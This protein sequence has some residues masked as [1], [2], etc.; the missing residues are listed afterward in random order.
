MG[1]VGDVIAYLN[2]NYFDSTTAGL[3]AVYGYAMN[4][5]SANENYALSDLSQMTKPDSWSDD[6]WDFSG[7]TPILKQNTSGATAV[8]SGTIKINN[9]SINLSGASIDDAISQINA[10]SKMIKNIRLM[11]FLHQ[12]RKSTRLNSSHSDRPRMPSSA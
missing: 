2:N 7:S 6:I 9:V 8:N 11:Q 5:V 3:S 10:Q 1:Y 12:D 4:G